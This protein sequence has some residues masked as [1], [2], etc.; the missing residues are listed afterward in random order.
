MSENC[1][2]S[3]DIVSDSIDERVFEMRDELDDDP[4]ELVDFVCDA[5]CDAEG[6][7]V[8]DKDIEN[9]T[10]DERDNRED[11]VTINDEE[12]IGDCV[13][14]LLP[15]AHPDVDRDGLG[16]AEILGD[17]VE[18][19]VA[20][21]DKETNKDFDHIGEVVPDLEMDAEVDNN[22]DTETLLDEKCE[23]DGLREKY[24]LPE[25]VGDTLE[26]LLVTLVTVVDCVN[27]AVFERIL[28]P[29]INGVAL[30][31]NVA[32]VETVARTETDELTVAVCESFPLADESALTVTTPL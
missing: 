23:I 15:E 26:L 18:S 2:T 1:V 8:D 24:G 4:E 10:D 7:T 25:A 13:Y 28:V 27:A 19:T 9:D 31:V 21:L 16:E 6:D 30:A 3:G 11:T 12:V 29:L 17:D 22:A 20:E 14:T 5:E 32:I